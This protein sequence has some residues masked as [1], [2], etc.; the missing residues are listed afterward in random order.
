M[1]GSS[2]VTRRRCATLAAVM[3]VASGLTS[4]RCGFSPNSV[5]SS[6]LWLAGCAGVGIAD[7]RAVGVETSAG[8]VL[9][10]ALNS[11]P[12]S[13]AT[14]RRELRLDGILRL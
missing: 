10:H 6:R 9:P 1:P 13:S 7:G 5:Q 2:T 14:A 11:T 8:A 3:P 4:E 12:A